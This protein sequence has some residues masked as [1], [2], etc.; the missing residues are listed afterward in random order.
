MLHGMH[1]WKGIQFFVHADVARHVTKL[2]IHLAL[3]LPLWTSMVI[4]KQ[5]SL[6]TWLDKWLGVATGRFQRH[7]LVLTG[8]TPRNMQENLEAGKIKDLALAYAPNSHP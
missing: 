2:P 3:P 1:L 4:D 8:G 6:D 5:A 7:H